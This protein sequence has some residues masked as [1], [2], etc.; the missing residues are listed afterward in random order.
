MMKFE[1]LLFGH[2]GGWDEILLVVAPLGLMA[3]LL[4][5]A[6]RKAEKM[7]PQKKSDFGA[8]NDSKYSDD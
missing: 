1:H 8:E 4:W 2:Q 6:N 3:W 5:A 7:D